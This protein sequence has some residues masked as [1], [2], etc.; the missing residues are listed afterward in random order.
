MIKN[1][2]SISA[3]LFII[4]SLK[5]FSND[6]V[7]KRLLYLEQAATLH[8]S[9]Y[10]LVKNNIPDFLEAGPKNCEDIAKE[11]NFDPKA[12]ARFLDYLV[13][14]EVLAKNNDGM[15]LNSNTS[16]EFTSG[17][18]NSKA[19]FILMDNSDRK[20]AMQDSTT[21]LQ[22]NKSFFQNKYNA[23]YWGKL[24]QNPAE[25]EVFNKGME[26]ISAYEE[27]LI[28]KFFASNISSGTVLDV[29]G[30]TGKLLEQIKKENDS[31][32]K[33][34]LKYCLLELEDTINSIEKK[35]FEIDY[36]CG[37]FLEPIQKK[38]ENIILKRVLHNWDDEHATKI[39]KNCAEALTN[40]GTLFII[41]G[42]LDLAKN[43]Q[44][45]RMFDLK[46]LCIFGGRERSS[47]EFDTLCS[48]AELKISKCYQITETM[49]ILECKKVSKI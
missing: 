13:E 21:S 25:F 18:K 39:L 12:L 24:K 19:N 32:N 31:T 22:S 27:E 30:G 41:D 37:S 46:M 48:S 15:Y 7:F 23:S 6:P 35:H 28:A 36:I 29:G 20:L 42:V 40:N 43:K 14:H 47:K 10:T 8:S 38:S 9:I 5:P 1:F 17:H 11:N 3:C 45:I 49:N 4:S 44:L 16:K 2:F 33:K 26:A 34:D